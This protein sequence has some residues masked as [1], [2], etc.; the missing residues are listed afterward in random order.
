MRMSKL[1]TISMAV[2][3]ILLSVSMVSATTY[4]WSAAGDGSFSD[5]SKWTPAGGPP[6]AADT[7][8]FN[9]GAATAY[10]VTLGSAVTNTSL[11]VK[12]DNVSIDLGGYTYTL[13]SGAAVGSAGGDN[14]VLWLSN[15]TLDVDDSAEG[16]LSLGVSSSGTLNVNGTG[17][18][19]V[20][21]ADYVCL[22]WPGVASA[23]YINVTGGASLTL[24]NTYN[25]ELASQTNS[26]G[27]VLVSGENSTFTVTEGSVLVGLS[28]SI[29][30]ST[31]TVENGGTFNLDATANFGVGYSA[32][33]VGTVTV[34][35]GTI[36]LCDNGEKYGINGFIGKN[37]TGS[38]IV[39]NGGVFN[40]GDDDAHN[41][42]VGG[43]SSSGVGSV[44]VGSIGAGTATFRTLYL[45]GTSVGVKGVGH[46]I[47]GSG[48]NVTVYSKLLVYG[49]DGGTVATSDITMYDGG[50]LNV[51]S[52]GID[53]RGLLQGSG[54]IAGS[55][56]GSTN[57]IV[58]NKGTV[59]PGDATTAGT[60]TLSGV[61]LNLSDAASVLEIGFDDTGAH[62][63]VVLTDGSTAITS[64]GTVAYSLLSGTEFAPTESGFMDFLIAPTITGTFTADN[65]TALMDSII[66]EGTTYTYGLVTVGAGDYAGGQ[67]GG[68]QALRLTYVVPEPAT[69]T[70]LGLGGMLVLARKKRRAVS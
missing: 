2:F 52:L 1:S 13:T 47:V 14:G 24:N 46:L 28:S 42:Y 20:V 65:M 67:Y 54:T 4:D 64:G 59:A 31:M 10:T 51:S 38:L 36:N 70:L 68:D 62:D 11:Y 37:G 33:A 19:V 49:G 55:A 56:T 48:G 35:N 69:M 53:Q 8:Q 58:A 12:N 3:A 66:A 63:A 39:K 6:A 29:N 61:N 9:L 60:L 50:V 40:G 43:G 34:D 26:Q 32:G 45:G 16:I 23:G 21:M 5:A 27:H 22:G 18:T 25:L 15:G 57:Y 44:D 30:E 7:A 17:N 41:M